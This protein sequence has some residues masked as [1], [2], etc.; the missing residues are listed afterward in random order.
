MDQY[1]VRNLGCNKEPKHA[2]ILLEKKIESD[3]E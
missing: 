1:S 2:V 3:E